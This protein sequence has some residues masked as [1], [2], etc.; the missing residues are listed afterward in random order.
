MD[1]IARKLAR[2]L[3]HIR[4]L[5]DTTKGFFQSQFYTTR[6][7]Q[8]NE[9]RWGTSIVDTVEPPPPLVG[10]LIGEAAHQLR[11]TLDHL[12]W[13]LTWPV[14]RREELSTEFPIAYSR[15]EFV[16]RKGGRG[17]DSHQGML[18]KM[19]RVARGVRATVESVQPYNSG[20]CKG[21]ESLGY[22]R[23]IS[24]WDKHRSLTTAVANVQVVELNLR[25]TGDGRL[26]SQETFV[27]AFKPGAVLARVEVEHD[28][29][30]EFHVH[31]KPEMALQP[32]FD[33]TMPEAIRG[34]PVVKSL[35][36]AGVFIEHTVIPKLASFL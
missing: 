13:L 31:M 23:A 10:I 2:S 6:T 4:A 34:V 26:K 21:A 28:G 33:D 3:E 29:G 14:G 15:R 8:D 9:A 16:G 25:I 36:D 30:A 7:E 12:M 19:P 35:H 22:L 24:N 1:D 17:V 27:G 20:K 32:M 5:N 11:S 18:Y